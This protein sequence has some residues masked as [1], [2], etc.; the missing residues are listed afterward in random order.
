MTWAVIAAFSLNSCSKDDDG[1]KD[2]PN[3]PQ[4]QEMRYVKS[5]VYSIP[6][7]PN[8]DGTSYSFEYDEQHRISKCFDGNT[9]KTYTFTYDQN[10]VTILCNNQEY[11]DQTTI[12]LQLNDQ[13]Y[14]ASIPFTTGERIVYE[15]DNDGYLKST[16][17]YDANENLFDKYSY[18]QQNGNIAT[19]TYASNTTSETYTYTY[20]SHK[21]LANLNL[22]DIFGVNITDGVDCIGLFFG[23]KKNV[24]LLASHTQEQDNG[25]TFT[26]DF[27]ENGYVTAVHGTLFREA[28]TKKI[29][30]Y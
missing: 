27:D 16:A 29:F 1:K 12:K 17:S 18:T 22:D 2:D 9:N 19:Q 21:N 5:I 10:S 8:H 30:Y 20:M 6:D 25:K 4:P 26:Y 11:N 3:D 24:N 14:A 15:Y 23:G 28:Y 7:N 13:G